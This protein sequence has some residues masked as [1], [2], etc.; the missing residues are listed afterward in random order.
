MQSRGLQEAGKTMNQ[1]VNDR[2]IQEEVP[3]VAAGSNP[4]LVATEP[5]ETAQQKQAKDDAEWLAVARDAY[6]TSEDYFDSSIR[7][8]IERNLAHFG[9]RHAPGSKYYS[10]AYKYRSK[11]FRPKTRSVVRRNEAK[12]A[13]ALFSTSGVVHVAPENDSD[14]RQVV[15]AEINQELVNYR[16][17]NTIPWY[18]ICMGAYQDTSVQGVCISHQFWD[19]QE[20]EEE[21]QIFVDGQP[22]YDNETGDVAVGMRRRIIKDSPKIELRPIENVRFS[23]AADWDDPV[24]TSPYVVDVIPMEIG[25]VQERI[26]RGSKLKV[27]WRDVGEGA[28]RT[29]SRDYDPIRSQ[30]EQDR[31]DSKDQSHATNE[32]DIVW[33]HRNIVRRRGRDYIFYTV[34][35][36]HM[37]SDVVPLETE[38]PH[39][40]PG[41]RPYVLGVSNIETHK[42]YPEADAGLVANL[43]QEANDIGNQR[44]DNVALVLNRRYYAKRDAQIDYRTLK[45]SVPG[46]I[47][48]MND[49]ERDI[50]P[51][52]TR[53]VTGSSYSEQDRINMDFDELAGSFSNSSVA[54]NRKLNETVGGMEMM[55]A[56]ADEVTE[57][58]LRTFVQTWVKPVIKQLIRLEQRFETDEAIFRMVGDKI[59][60]WEKYQ[61]DQITDEMLQGSM[62]VEVNV[63]F[64]ATNPKQRIEKLTMGMNTVLNFAPQMQMRVKG[65]EVASEVFGAL[66][67]DGSTRFFIPEEEMEQQEQQ[68]DPRIAVAKLNAQVKQMEQETKERIEMA[69]LS[70]N[71]EWR[72]REA[73]VQLMLAD[74]KS[75][76]ETMK[77]QG[78]SVD[79]IRKVKAD[80][81]KLVMSIKSSERM[82]GI[83]ANQAPKPPYEPPGRASAG[84]SVVQ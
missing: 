60:A 55:S 17:D 4:D 77:V 20:I 23:P 28:L 73:E 2:D 38:Y 75:Q 13:I 64:G 32:F 29:A 12:A 47:V 50:K 44:R 69:K 83:K 67:Y 43:Q 70:A 8:K 39:L 58:K 45:R 5:E 25:D 46:G 63:G 14:D 27:P 48:E 52:D 7:K 36:Q 24:N 78:A 68:E 35:T 11:G 42:N 56:G 49:I 80:I 72:Q 76:L 62:T 71:G 3:K 41:E 33:I 82:V 61:I 9:N 81:A 1:A 66:G 10:D 30:R 15:S 19:F 40:R 51:E 16:L 21:E 84:M 26:D 79:S 74:L 57:Y 65:D 18:M 54:S 59:Q 22:V 37:L 53:D 34:G 31:Q 6:S